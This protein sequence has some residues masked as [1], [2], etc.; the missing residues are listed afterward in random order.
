MLPRRYLFNG[1]FRL[2]QIYVIFLHGIERERF[3]FDKKIYY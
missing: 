3:P 1:I 2:V